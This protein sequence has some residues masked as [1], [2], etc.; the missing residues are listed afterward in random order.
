MVVGMLS[1][2]LHRRMIAEDGGLQAVMPPLV[3][4]F[5]LLTLASIALPGMNGFVGEFLILIGAF[6]WNAKLTAFAATGVTQGAL[7]DGV[8]FTGGGARS[9]SVVMRSRTGTVR[10]IDTPHPINS[11]P[12]SSGATSRRA[13]APHRDRARPDSC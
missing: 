6:L 8:R 5:L 2:R 12:A 3:A 7:L 11:P 1:D 4:V 9:Q 13:R 10:V